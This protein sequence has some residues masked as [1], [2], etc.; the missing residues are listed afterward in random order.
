MIKLEYDKI[1]ARIK[2]EKG[3]SDEEINSRVDKKLK[4]LSGLISK[5]GAAHIIANELGIKLFENL[6]KEVVKVNEL[7]VGMRKVSVVG[8]VVNVFGVNSFKTEK[9]EG[10]VGSF[11]IG[12]DTGRV[13]IVLWDDNQIVNMENGNIKEDVIVKVEN[14]YVRENN[15]FK[16]VHLNVNSNL[17]LNPEGVVIDKVAEPKSFSVNRKKISE[18]SENDVY[19]DVLGTVVQLFEPRFYHACELCGKKASLVGDNYKCAEHDKAVVKELPVVNFYFDDGSGN[20]RVVAFRDVAY[21]ILG[22]SGVDEIKD[23]NK[24]EEIKNKIL[25]SQF[26]INARVSKNTMFDRIE[27]VAN[28]VSNINPEELITELAK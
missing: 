24:F 23:V 13:R 27:L 19:V 11:I 1:I 7:L 8:K 16:E 25:G 9:R 3:L 4:D 28:R 14:A 5:E 26:I 6:G 18:L 21:E 20:I 22:V 2:E 12:D 17:V 15:G 10:K